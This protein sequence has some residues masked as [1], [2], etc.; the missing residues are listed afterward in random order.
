MYSCA[1]EPAE[2]TNASSLGAGTHTYL[3]VDKFAVPAEA[4]H[5]PGHSVGVSKHIGHGHLVDSGVPEGG[6]GGTAS[7]MA[8][9]VVVVVDED[10][11]VA[12]GHETP[13]LSP[14]SVSG[15]TAADKVAVCFFPMRD[16]LTHRGTAQK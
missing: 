6:D 11:G 1:D 10:Q 13:S 7:T 5:H 16:V 9:L 4:G 14:G 15:F 2:G 12:I 3:S 8:P